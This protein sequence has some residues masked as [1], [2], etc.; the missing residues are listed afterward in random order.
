V[1][2]LLLLTDDDHVDAH[3]YRVEGDRARH[4]REILGVES[5]STVRAGLLE[6]AMGEA[7]VLRVTPAAV[8]LEAPLEGDPPPRAGV[9]L[10]LAIPR[11]IM[12]RRLLPQIVALGVDR[13]VLL[14]TWRVEKSYLSARI[15]R[16]EVYRPLLH[17]GMSQ[18][19]TT[20]EPRVT[21]EPLFRPFVEDRVGEL[22]AGTRRIVGHP[23]AT[24]PLAEIRV[25]ADE[26]VAIAIGPEGGFLPFE[27]DLLQAA[28]FEGV[29]LGDRTLRVDTAALAFLAQIGL[30]RAQS[31][32]R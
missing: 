25:G 2:N 22:L 29:T 8:E 6:G 19:R 12:L 1:V 16:P 4:M 3:R 17:E 14:R 30:L 18:A 32:R 15:L 31:V 28:G 27:L 13:L 21:V 10:V 20:R 9:D 24:T 26:R 5:G 7:R 11:P 23:L